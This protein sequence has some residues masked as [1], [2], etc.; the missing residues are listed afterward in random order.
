MVAGIFNP[1]GLTAGTPL[2][3]HGW[4]PRFEA[5]EGFGSATIE[6]V[7][8]PLGSQVAR[9][10]AEPPDNV[11]RGIAWSR[12]ELGS[13]VTDIEVLM[14]M[15]RNDTDSNNGGMFARG[16][17]ISSIS[18]TGSADAIGAGFRNNAVDARIWRL[19]GNVFTSETAINHGIDAGAWLWVRY[20]ATGSTHRMRT[21]EHGS[22]EPGTWLIDGTAQKT[23]PGWV[24]IGML[25]FSNPQSIDY[26]W[27][28]YNEEGEAEGPGG[29]PPPTTFTLTTNA[30]GSGSITL[31][32]AGGTYDENTVVAATAVPDSGWSFDGWSGALSGTTNPQN[33][34]MDAD[35][36]ITATFTEDT[37][38]T[39]D[40]PANLAAD[41][42]P[43]VEL[44]W[45]AV[46]GTSI[47]YDVE[48][49]STVVA[50]GLTATEYRDNDVVVDTQYSY[51]VRADDD[52]VKG[53]WSSTVTHTPTATAAAQT[54]YVW[55]GTQWV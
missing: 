14:L 28:S 41:T 19:E 5:G 55:D 45:N 23:S 12:D 40:A 53:D 1:D 47:T 38:G 18:P 17:G 3:D 39:P 20:Q 51:R 29:D 42:A 21:W 50:T 10:S 4:F 48:R 37:A 36:T 2:T 13:D 44:T 16:E 31:D 15:R 25:V 27:F 43:A 22:S 24:G 49:D 54:E 6:N 35:K 30:V 11:G 32:P 8:S 26:A 9:I 34:T 46:A 33:V 52:G 7:T